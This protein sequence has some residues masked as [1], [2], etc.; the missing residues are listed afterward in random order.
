MNKN[1]FS[2]TDEQLREL[3]NKVTLI[4]GKLGY[5]SWQLTVFNPIKTMGEENKAPVST[6]SGFI[7]EDDLYKFGDILI[8]MLHAMVDKGIITRKE[9]K[10]TNEI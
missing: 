6:L 5:A 1:L 4:V 7:N 10:D 9:C 3:H 2:M 8:S